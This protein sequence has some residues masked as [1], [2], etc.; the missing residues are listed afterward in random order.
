MEFPAIVT[1]RHDKKVVAGIGH[2]P[3]QPSRKGRH[4]RICSDRRLPVTDRPESAFHHRVLEPM[5]LLSQLALQAFD[6]CRDLSP[7]INALVLERL[8][9]RDNR[10]SVGSS[11]YAL[12]LAVGHQPNLHPIAVD[13]P[14]AC[15]V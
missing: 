1:C 13:N 3:D 10:F 11:D 7:D 9:R 4:D 6:R 2:L 8:L 5:L 12:D 14:G 15:S